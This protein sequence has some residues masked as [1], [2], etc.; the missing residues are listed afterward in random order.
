[1]APKHSEDFKREAVRI[2]THS[3]LPPT[4]GLGSRP[5]ANGCEIIPQIQLLPRTWSCAARASTF[6]CAS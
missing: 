2:A 1:M 6:P 3:G 4:S 5:W